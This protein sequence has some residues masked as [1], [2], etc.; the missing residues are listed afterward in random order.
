MTTS[1]K[2]DHPNTSELILTIFVV[3]IVSLFLGTIIGAQGQLV[4]LRQA[5]DQHSKFDGS[6][7][8]CRSGCRTSED[9]RCAEVH[10]WLR[11]G[12]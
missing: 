9:V 4:S 11:G 8:Y 5:L 2:K 12:R 3:A 7:G 6:L 10:E 1:D